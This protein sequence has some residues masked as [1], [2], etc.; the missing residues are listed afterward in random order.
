MRPSTPTNLRVS[1]PARNAALVFLS[2]AA[3]KKKTK[4]KKNSAKPTAACRREKRK[5]KPARY[6]QKEGR[7][8]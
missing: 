1:T 2:R 6:A 4:K 5:Q 8:P 3:K 7:F